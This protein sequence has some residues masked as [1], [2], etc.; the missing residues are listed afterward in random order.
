MLGF[1]LHG[2]ICKLGLP[3]PAVPR[4][5]FVVLL[6]HPLHVQVC[7]GLHGAAQWAWG[8]ESARVNAAWACLGLPSGL[9]KQILLGLMLLGAA[10]GCPVGLGT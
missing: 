8:T 9:G 3:T 5:A 1:T 6:V 2:V 7:L 4:W 10:W